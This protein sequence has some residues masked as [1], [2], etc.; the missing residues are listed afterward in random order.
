MSESDA[1]LQAATEQIRR[2]QE[3]KALRPS[4]AGF[5][6]EATYTVS[7]VVHWIGPTSIS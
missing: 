4:I 3:T 1:P 5:F 6:D 7:Y 2:A